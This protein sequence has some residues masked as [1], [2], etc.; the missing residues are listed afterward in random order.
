MARKKV[1]QEPVRQTVTI[2]VTD[3]YVDISDVL[4][5]RS[6]AEVIEVM[7]HY[8]ERFQGRDVY[9][10][11]ERYGYDGGLDLKLYE[12]RLENDREF[13]R[14][15]RLEKLAKDAAEKETAKTI[16]RERKEYL[17]LKKKFEKLEGK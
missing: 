14:R 13:E 6:P 2:P 4:D 7:Q 3:C 1:A 5:G 11:V 8:L 9:F 15:I 17:R 16:E 10:N 12:R